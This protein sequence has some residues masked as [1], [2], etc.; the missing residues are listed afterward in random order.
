MQPRS[1]KLL[2]DIRD[3]A[4]FIRDVAQGKN[5]VDYNADRV[6][7]QARCNLVPICSAPTL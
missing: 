5:L 3:A 4:A 6:L 2:E 7:R 1:P